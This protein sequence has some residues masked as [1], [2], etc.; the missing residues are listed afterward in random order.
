MR[1][2]EE[3]REPACVADARGTVSVHVPAQAR[4]LSLIA[5]LVQWF[6]RRAGLSD[7][8]WQELEVAV[9]EA[10]TNVVRH[11]FPEGVEG[12]M[13][14]HFALLEQGLRVTIVDRGERFSP[15]RGM[16][17]AEAKRLRDPASG[18]NGLLLIA[19]LTDENEYRW[20]ERE[21]NRLTLV[22]YR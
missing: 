22:K 2:L 9:D 12:E 3:A 7:E 19:G 21:G 8:R 13:T 16:E 20:D 10:C 4:Y 5:T 11:A 18:G 14:V 15:S 1:S 17:I 6:G